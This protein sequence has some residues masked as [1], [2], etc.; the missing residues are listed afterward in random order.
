M[1]PGRLVLEDSTPAPLSGSGLLNGQCVPTYS[2]TIPPATPPGV[3]RNCSVTFA[4][5]DPSVACFVTNT[6]TG[7]SVP[8][9]KGVGT[10]TISVTV[11]GF[12]GTIPTVPVTVTGAG[13]PPC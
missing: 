6:I 1:T 9:A 11:Q 8:A 13:K 10:T 7:A 12:K 3:D 4:S 5:A 2:P